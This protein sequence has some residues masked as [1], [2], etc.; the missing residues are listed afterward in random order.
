MLPNSSKFHCGF[1]TIPLKSALYSKC[2]WY[3]RESCSFCVV[4][5]TLPDH[6]HN[7]GNLRLPLHC[8]I[9]VVLKY[10]LLAP[11]I[12]CCCF[13]TCTWIRNYFLCITSLQV[14]IMCAS[15][16]KINSTEYNHTQVLA[17]VLISLLISLFFFSLYRESRFYSDLKLHIKIFW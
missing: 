6:I 9:S 10:P 17:L 11:L 3:G 5:V 1:K 8:R 4:P 14:V 2:P 15:I 16:P 12:D 7:L 13:Y